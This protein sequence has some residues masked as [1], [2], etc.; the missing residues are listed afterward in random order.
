M[1]PPAVE[2][3]L[4]VTDEIVPSM[5]NRRTL[6]TGKIIT[7]QLILFRLFPTTETH[8]CIPGEKVRRKYIPGS[9]SPQGE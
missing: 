7:R 6:L 2:Y 8:F 3:R 5:Q 4:W 9:A 1:V